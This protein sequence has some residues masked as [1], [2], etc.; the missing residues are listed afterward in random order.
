MNKDPII[1]DWKERTLKTFLEE[2]DSK[3]FIKSTD[4]FTDEE[5]YLSPVIEDMEAI[6]AISGEWDREDLKDILEKVRNQALEEIREKI[7]N[8]PIENVGNSAKTVE[9][10]LSI[11]DEK[12]K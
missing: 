9:Q 10:V 1:Q 3:V 6:I 7:E 5:E 2:L 11:I 8:M 4:S 12:L